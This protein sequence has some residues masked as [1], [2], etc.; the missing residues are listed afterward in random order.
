MS[1]SPNF[2]I[3]V[4]PLRTICNPGDDE[5][6]D[7]ARRAYICPCSLCVTAPVFLIRDV[8]TAVKGML[9]EFR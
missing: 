9:G 4:W 7:L 1:L 5:K 6:A 8:S 2:A 3:I